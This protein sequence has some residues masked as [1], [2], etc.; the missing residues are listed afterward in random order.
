MSG[1]SCQSSNAWIHALHWSPPIPL[2]TLGTASSYSTCP[3]VT[4][5]ATRSTTSLHLVI[6]MEVIFTAMEKQGTIEHECGFLC[7]CHRF[8]C[9]DPCS[10]GCISRESD[11]IQC[12]TKCLCTAPTANMAPRTESI[13]MSRAE[14][15]LLVTTLLRNF[16]WVPE[17][18]T[19]GASKLSSESDDDSPLDLG[20]TTE[21]NFSKRL[22]VHFFFLPVHCKN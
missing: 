19:M 15:N 9:G 22:D 4:R 12:Y 18:V 1:F 21:V 20:W 17:L 8:L 10:L 14:A 11:I 5:T 16:L 6:Y 3:P 2:P 7:Y 13:T